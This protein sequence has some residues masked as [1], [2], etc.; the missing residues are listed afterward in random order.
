MREYERQ[1]QKYTSILPHM[2]ERVFA[3]LALLLVAAVMTVSASFAWVV[4]SVNPEI[5][6]LATTISANGNLEIAL[7]NGTTITPPG[8]S[9]VGDGGKNLVEKNITWGNLINLGDASYGLEHITLRP[10]TLN[11]NDLIGQPLYG[12]SYGADGRVETLVKDYAYAYWN[13]QNSVFS[14]DQVRYGV[15]TVSSVTYTEVGGNLALTQAV[16]AADAAVITAKS[17]VKSIINDP[18]LQD[19]LTLVGDYVQAQ[20]DEKTSGDGV[21]PVVYVS[22]NQV[23]SIHYLM[24]EL[25]VNIE[26]SANALAAIYNIAM[27]RHAGQSYM[28]E[29]KFTGEYLLTATTAEIQTKL[30]TKNG[31]EVIV[32]PAMLSQLWQLRTDYTTIID[33]IEYIG[34]L[35]GRGDVVYRDLEKTGAPAI[36]TYVCHIADVTSCTI[37]GTPIGSLSASS[38]MGMLFGKKS[39]VITKGIFQRMDKFTGAEAKT[40]NYLSVKVMGTTVQGKVS[41]S[42]AAPFVLPT[43]QE[44]AL[45]SDTSYKGSDPVAQDT[46]GMALDFFLRTNAPGSHLVLQGSPVYAEREETA[47]ATIGTNVY[48]LYKVTA[49]DESQTAYLDTKTNTYYAYDTVTESAGLALGTTDEITDATLM[50]KTVKYVV[51]YS[52]VNRVWDEDESAFIDGDSTTQGAGSCYTFYAS[53]PE[54]QEKAIELLQYLRVAFVDQNGQLLAEAYLNTQDKFEQTGKVTIPLVLE[55]QENAVTGPNGTKINTITALPV[56]TPT[57]VTALVYLEGSTLS[58]DMVLAAGEIQGQLNIQFG[59][60]ADLD[61]MDDPEQMQAKCY[62][63]AT[64][65]GNGTTIPF[66][67]ATADQLKKQVEVTVTGYNPQKVEAYFLR[68]I[69][70]YQGVRQGKMTFTKN[71]EG[72]WV[73]EHQFTYPG[74]YVLRDVLLDGVTYELDHDPITFTVEGFTITDV[75]CPHDGKTYM[76]TNRYFDTSV[77]MTFA[78]SDLSKMPSSVKGAFIHTETGDR[79]TVYFTNTSGSTWSGEAT[80]STSGEYRLEYVELNDQYTGLAEEQF[81]S[82]KLYLGLTTSVFTGETNLA[83]EDGQPRDVEVTM[84]VQTDKGDPITGLTGV[85]LQYSNNGS[86]IQENGVGAGMVWSAQRKA[87]VGTFRLTKGGIYN[88]HYASINIDGELN[89]LYT[90]AT[91]PTITAISTTP[92]RYVSKDGFGEV[93]TLTNNAAFTVRMRGADSATVDAELK[94]EKGNTYYVRGVPAVQGNEQVFTFT[95]PLVEG[96]QSGTWSLQGLYL[97]NVYGGVNTSLYNAPIE[98]GP[99]TATD[100]KPLY[101]VGSNYYRRWLYW[102]LSEMTAEDESDANKSGTLTVVNNIEVAVTDA[103]ANQDKDFGKDADGNVTATFGTSHVLTDAIELQ[104]TAGNDKSPLSNYGLTV[105]DAKLVYSYDRTSVK[106][107]GNGVIT[108]AYGGY[109]VTQNWND[110]TSVSKDVEFNSISAAAG[111]ATKYLLAPPAGATFTVAGR[112]AATGELLLTL[113]DTTGTTVQIKQAAAELATPTYSVWSKAPTA[114]FVSTDPKVGEQFDIIKD[115]NGGDENNITKGSNSISSDGLHVTCYYKIST[116]NVMGCTVCSGGTPSKVTAELIDAG[117]FKTGSFTVN[118][119]GNFENVVFAF[120]P[121]SSGN[122][123]NTQ[124][125][126]EAVSAEQAQNGEMKI[127]G[128]NAT[129]TQIILTDTD[130]YSYIF[131]LPTSQYLTI[132]GEK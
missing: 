90:A 111:D 51:G 36:E 102:P 13:A 40:D 106:E 4:L 112:Y 32:A 29:N 33:D 2:R 47:T 107:V 101:T 58:N 23:K 26:D 34:S 121:A 113:R 15:R 46:Y 117:N 45:G 68:E 80:F 67:T 115:V 42:A 64:M 86:N 20:I 129:A 100:D 1:I 110:I 75:S 70:S 44:T 50:T 105:T 25:K 11:K 131:D 66:D 71:A 96:R 61:A 85:W 88:Y 53:S 118:S 74:K 17:G 5:K 126:G 123:Q 128:T 35:I 39:I 65:D 84:N 72:K 76:T 59:T 52:G 28:A 21:E 103:A 91:A 132:T 87:Y 41:T 55:E 14:A 16:E 108:N 48:N 116:S 19:L 79:T 24:G 54:D 94:N 43:E 119:T 62:V 99:D 12:A 7:A 27:L 3:A 93:F 57:F 125:I 69:N 56:N 122:P 78:S 120:E 114:K 97:T 104:I 63:S 30:A 92:A 77:S 95:V 89:Y 73:G 124:S 37:D 10:A 8:A 109:T 81:V 127:I 38:A 18:A 6:G 49:G 130:G 22:D 98:D 31:G 9:Q 60:T 82:I 83:L